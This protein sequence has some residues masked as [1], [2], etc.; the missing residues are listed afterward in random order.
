MKEPNSIEELEILAKG[1]IEEKKKAASYGYQPILDILKNDSS[2]EVVK[3][4]K[5]IDVDDDLKL[6][7][8]DESNES[9]KENFNKSYKSYMSY[10]Y[11]KMIAIILGVI[12]EI[13]ATITLLN[14]YN[15]SVWYWFIAGI[16]LLVISVVFNS[17]ANRKYEVY[18]V[19]KQNLIQTNSIYEAAKAK[20]NNLINGIE[21]GYK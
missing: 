12:M 11:V 7:K 15:N 17:I 20:F 5:L 16:V 2:E 10:Y 8:A 6:Y 9:A 14:T 18:I 1:T 4:A 13:I 19:D 21:N 3:F